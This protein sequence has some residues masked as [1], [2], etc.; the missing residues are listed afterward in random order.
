MTLPMD[1]KTKTWAFCFPAK[2][3]GIVRLANRFEVVWS[4]SEVS[5]DF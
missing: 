1:K 3:E 5:I 4:Q 2:E